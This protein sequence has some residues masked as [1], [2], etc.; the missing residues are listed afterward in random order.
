MQKTFCYF[1]GEMPRWQSTPTSELVGA[2]VMVMGLVG[3]SEVGLPWG[4]VD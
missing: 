2:K 3:L 4:R 1:V